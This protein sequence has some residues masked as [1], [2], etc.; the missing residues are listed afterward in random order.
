MVALSHSLATIVGPDLEQNLAIGEEGEKRDPR[1]TVLPTKLFD[2][3]RC[4]QRRDSGHDLRIANL[5]QR[6]GARRFQNH[7]AGAPS[8]VGE[9]RE[10]ENVGIA[11]RRHSWPV[12]GR[13]RFYDDL[14]LIVS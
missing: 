6:P 14:V 3:L 7:V 5:E 13:L 11:K 12:I 8:H 1:K 9:S 4:R 10:H 2:L